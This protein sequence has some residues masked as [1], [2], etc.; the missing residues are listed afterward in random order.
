MVASIWDATTT[1]LQQ[2]FSDVHDLEQAIRIGLRLLIAAL[3]G[4]LLGLQRERSGKAAGIRTHMLV[5]MGS[6]LFVLVSQ[7]S[8]VTPTDISRV[9][10]GIIAGIGF[11][12][13][14]TILK[15]SDTAHVR[16]L[17][18]AAGI[19]LTAA[20]GMAAGLGREMTAVLST[21][22][23]VAVLSLEP[24]LRGISDRSRSRRKDQ[25]PVDPLD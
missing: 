7:Q 21:V 14:G 22:L 20:I 9:A 15:D 25:A 11:L 23:A 4:G 13:A 5:S 10:Q 3:L 1:V 8:G 19:W 17:T 6:A 16:G 2:E 12:G 24:V 18:T